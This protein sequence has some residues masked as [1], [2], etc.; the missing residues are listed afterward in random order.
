MRRNEGNIPRELETMAAELSPGDKAHPGIPKCSLLSFSYH[1]LSQARDWQ[2]TVLVR[3][4]RM[5]PT[6]G[7][8]NIS[9]KHAP[10]STHIIVLFTLCNYQNVW[11]SQW[12]SSPNLL[13]MDSLIS[14]CYQESHLSVLPAKELKDRK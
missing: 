8:Q 13:H 3:K 6:K 4:R 1:H 7:N 14:Y 10:I 2:P 11:N 9:C 12:K 5:T